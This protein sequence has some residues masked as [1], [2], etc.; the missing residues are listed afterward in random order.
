MFGNECGCA[1]RGEGRGGEERGTYKDAHMCGEGGS[2]RVRGL[3]GG[4]GV[5]VVWMGIRMRTGI[6]M[7]V[8]GIGWMCDGRRKEV[9]K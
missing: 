5:E 8:V 1:G 3:G 9:R 2:A 4:R 6:R 7:R